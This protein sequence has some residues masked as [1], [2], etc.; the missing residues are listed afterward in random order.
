MCISGQH[1]HCL[2]HGV[3]QQQRVAAYPPSGLAA[4][5]LQATT[6]APV[7]AVPLSRTVG[8]ELFFDRP[9]LMD[10]HESAGEAALP[11]AAHLRDASRVWHDQVWHQNAFQLKKAGIT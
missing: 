9:F 7:D 10:V 8:A 11:R 3:L 5:N 1:F 4:D 6:L 2:A